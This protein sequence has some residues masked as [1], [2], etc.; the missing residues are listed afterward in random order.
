[1]SQ[2]T[3][4]PDEEIESLLKDPKAQAWFEEHLTQLRQDAYGQRILYFVLAGAFVGASWPTSPA[5]S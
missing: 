1:M 4:L 3:Q 2:T 5:T